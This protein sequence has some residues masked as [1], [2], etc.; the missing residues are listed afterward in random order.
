MGADAA[1]RSQ[2]I[3]L[4]LAKLSRVRPEEGSAVVNGALRLQAAMRRADVDGNVERWLDAARLLHDMPAGVPSRTALRQEISER[5]AT[6]RGR[7][8]SRLG[9]LWAAHRQASVVAPLLRTALH[10]PTVTDDELF[11]TVEAIKARTVLDDL[12]GLHR[13][14]PEEAGEESS[15]LEQS[16]V[17]FAD[18]PQRGVMIE[19][20]RHVSALPLTLATDRGGDGRE[21]LREL[22]DLHQRHEAGYSG[23][24]PVPTLA[25]VRATLEPGDLLVEFVVLADP[26]E[27]IRQVWLLAITDEGVERVAC[28]VALLPDDWLA[29]QVQIDGQQ[30]LDGGPLLSPIADLRRAIRLGEDQEAEPLLR[31]L[32]DV[33]VAPLL[34]GGR[35]WDGVR[36]LVTVPHGP[37]HMVPWPALTDPDGRRLVEHVPLVTAPSAAAW[38]SLAR[39]A[40]RA[41]DSAL[42]VGAP[43][44]PNRPPLNY[45]AAEI[46]EIPAALPDTKVTRLTGPDATE[47][48]LREKA[49][50]QGIIHVAT[51]GRFPEQNPLRLHQLE[52]SADATTDGV[53]DAE[54]LR[55]LDLRSARLVVLN[56]CDGGLYRFGP[57]DEP[58]G[59]VPA[60]LSAGA[61]AVLAPTW[62][63]DDRRAA[64]FMADF[65]RS[66]PATDPAE[67]LRRAMVGR[68]GD[69]LLRDWCGYVLVGDSTEWSR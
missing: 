23:T 16:L 28:P 57:G 36:R 8:R 43:V 40:R 11:A 31:L 7:Y 19:E 30:P 21:V 49:A 12:A 45:A 27:P 63:V 46:D 9:R 42:L 62:R 64:T 58:Y 13:P 54:T 15:R 61:R 50:G 66:L 67:S 2:R 44:L 32:H 51:H 55:G 4:A 69:F 22:E 47:T 39:R 37:L 1:L 59:I 5:A 52:L 14:L 65:Y 48:A 10:D 20:L 60:L 17:T 53:V 34:T 24:A 26:P 56:L 38:C 18:S 35:T 41:D 25:D 68:V 29:R 33:L 6:I 3:A